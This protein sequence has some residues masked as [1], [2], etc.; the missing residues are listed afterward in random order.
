MAEQLLQLLSESWG[1]VA[2]GRLPLPDVTKMLISK[3]RRQRQQGPRGSEHRH[4]HGCHSLLTAPAWLRRC[5]ATAY[6][7]S[8]RL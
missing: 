4:W 3:A 5:W 7:S 1:F 2:Q 6:S 8:L